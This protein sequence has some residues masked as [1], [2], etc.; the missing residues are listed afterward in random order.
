MPRVPGLLG[1]LFDEQGRGDRQAREALFLT[2]NVDLGFFETRLLGT[3]RSAGAAVTVVADG[4]VFDPDARSVR[5]AGYSY[6]LGV[7]AM[8]GAFHPKLTVLAGPQRAVIG[9]G[10]GNLTVSGWHANDEV[11]TTVLAGCDDGIPTLVADVTAFLARLP[12][13]VPMSALARDGVARTAAQLAALLDAGPLRDTG[14]QLLHS[15]DRPI[16]E[17]LPHQP[18]DTLELSAPFHDLTGRALDALID[19]FKPHE[20]RILVQPGQTVI[21]PAVLQHAAA[22]HGVALRFLEPSQERSGPDPYRHGKL[23]TALAQGQPTWSLV[24]SANLS[25]A[26]LLGTAPSS[27]CEIAVLSGTGR[28]LFPT[29]TAPVTDS[30][31]LRH[32]I[33]DAAD[34]EET[35]GTA[36]VRLLE[37]RAVDAGVE[38]TVSAPAPY[39][40]V[41]EYSHFEWPPERFAAIGTVPAGAT[42][43]VFTVLLAPRTRIRMGE[44]IQFLAFPD[45]VVARLRP[46]GGDRVNH[47]ALP[48]ELFA[49]DTIAA[50]WSAA[51]TRLLLTHGRASTTTVASSQPPGHDHDV[52]HDWRTLDDPDAWAEYSEGALNRL[53]LPIFQLASGAT[54]TKIVGAALPNAAPAWEDRFDDTSDAYEEDQTAE[55]VD[56][57]EPDAPTPTADL[58]AARRT[59]LRSWIGS[60]AQLSPALPPLECIAIAQLVT[61]GTSA[62]IWNADSGPDGWF[63][64]LAT[65]LDGLARE[66]WPPAAQD[67][68]AAVAA[69]GLY[70]LRMAVPDDERGPAADAFTRLAGSLA[71]LLASV[72][73]EAVA[74]NITLLDGATLHPR[75][76]QEILHELD[77][78][79]QD[80]PDAVIQR[81][82][83]H[84]LPDYD[85]T[86]VTPR[87]L[88]LHGPGTNPVAIAAAVLPHAKA[89]TAVAIT[90]TTITGRRATVIRI[91][92][93]LTV[94]ETANGKQTFKTYRTAGLLGA[95]GVLSNAELALTRRL[96]TAPFTIAG[97]PDLEALRAVDLEPADLA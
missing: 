90:V 25:A 34:D 68:A 31:T 88:R 20:V 50:E 72:T 22:R 91:P 2:F 82:L 8:K 27:N 86:W 12:Q 60:L 21:D 14:H 9:I 81:V 19:R 56:A 62:L 24:G 64:P 36:V 49:S 77:S 28:S 52:L 97:D 96:S 87:H 70:R 11:L 71:P 13:V 89:L 85:T 92:D 67:Q 43:A 84:V 57:D 32:T 83:E 30:V 45:A 15:L 7:A 54:T 37:A 61:A 39:D 18:A 29:P 76:A 46:A 78:A 17:Q 6:A 53:G 94:V 58:S 4:S 69:I 35:D 65:A 33:G 48:A 47:N 5:A 93:R 41:L 3:V 10:S 23:I 55:T 51:L 63:T 16:L 79:L 44:Q 80:S 40:L 42:S 75:S 26:A 74:A 59:R 66:H 95:A 73:P 1:A 38:V